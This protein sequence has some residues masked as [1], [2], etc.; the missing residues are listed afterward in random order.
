[1]Y[2][3][4]KRYRNLKEISKFILLTLLVLLGQLSCTQGRVEN[5]TTLNKYN[6]GQLMRAHVKFKDNDTIVEFIYFQSGQ[7]N[8][9]RQLLNNQRTGWSYT[10]NKKG[11]LLFRESYLNGDLTGDFKAFYPTGQI[12]RIEHYQ[13]N[14]N[15]DTTIYYNKNGQVTM[16]VAYLAPCEFGSCECN[17]LVVVYENGSKVYSYAA[18]NGL[19]SENHT[20]YDQAVYQKLMAKNDEVHLR[21]EGKSIF[22]NNCGMCHKVD[23]QLVGIALDSFPKPMTAD[24]LVEI[25]GGSKG[26]PSTKITGKEAEE[27]IEY[28]NKNCP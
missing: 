4:V 19:K 27:L 16:K 24:E 23:K 15:I 14:K 5:R 11:E 9:K 10:Y 20:V 13:E 25:L 2:K 1:M 21:E 6:N 18:N 8:H 12:S 17:Q 22:R 3:A 7:L 26:H 28:I